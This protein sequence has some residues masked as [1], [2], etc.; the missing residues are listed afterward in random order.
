MSKVFS[1]FCSI[2][3]EEGCFRS[4]GRCECVSRAEAMMNGVLDFK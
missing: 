1:S 4:A 2:I 3:V